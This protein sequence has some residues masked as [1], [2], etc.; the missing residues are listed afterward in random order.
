MHIHMH[1]GKE[2]EK[3]HTNLQP[4]YFAV[5]QK[6]TRESYCLYIKIPFILGNFIMF[7]NID[8]IMKQFLMF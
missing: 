2:F 5:Q 3:E 8:Y 6:L 1:N 4:S 7:K